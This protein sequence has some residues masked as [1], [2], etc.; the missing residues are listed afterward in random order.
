MLTPPLPP[1]SGYSPC[2]PKSND[3]S[4]EDRLLWFEA[5]FLKTAVF[6]ALIFGYQH[7]IHQ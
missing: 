1:I 6:M 7:M 4:L 2:L 3:R 5:D